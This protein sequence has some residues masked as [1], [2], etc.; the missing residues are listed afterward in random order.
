MEHNCTAA[1]IPAP[2]LSRPLQISQITR[3]FRCAKKTILASVFSLANARAPNDFKAA[4]PIS[5]SK[6]EGNRPQEF[7]AVSESVARRALAWASAGGSKRVSTTTLLW[8]PRRPAARYGRPA[9]RTSGRRPETQTC[10]QSRRR[11]AERHGPG[12]RAGKRTRETKYGFKKRG[13]KAPPPDRTNSD[14][15]LVRV[16]LVAHTR[17]NQMRFRGHGCVIGVAFKSTIRFPKGIHLGSIFIDT[18]I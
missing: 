18:V 7:G 12:G 16:P 5:V 11:E 3:F 6:K 2:R 13:P 8:A 4:K 17:M 10:R 1:R 9:P 14:H 15:L